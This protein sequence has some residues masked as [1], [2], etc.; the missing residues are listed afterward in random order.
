MQM[1]KQRVRAFF[2]KY[3]MDYQSIDIAEQAE[4]FAREMKRGLAGEGGSL[5]MIP[6]FLGPANKLTANRPV[7]VLDAGGT[8]FRLAVVSFD[9]TNVPRIEDYRACAMPGTNAELESEE[10]FRTIAHLILPVADRSDTI[11]FCFSYACEPTPDCDGIIAEIGKQLQVKGLVGEKLGDRLNEA[12][13][14]L[15]YTRKKRILVINDSVATLLGGVAASGGCR[16]GGYIGFILGTGLNASYAEKLERIPK[17]M[18]GYYSGEELIINTESGDYNGFPCGKLDD[19]YD[20]TLIDPGT[21]R[22]EKMVAGRYQGGLA[23][24]VLRQAAKDGLFSIQFR[25]QI[26]AIKDLTSF[27]LDE[28]LDQPEG[29]NVLAKCCFGADS[30]DAVTAFYIIDALVERAAKLVAVNLAA[31][32]LQMNAGLNPLRPVCVTADGSTFY[33]SRLFRKKLD[34]YV[35][36]SLNGQLGLYCKFNH[37]ADVNLIGTAVAGLCI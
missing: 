6:T 10:F 7:L 36:Q 1:I 15:G 21:W 25:N 30:V 11:A 19:I 29:D 12:L 27:Q 23:L 37:V 3:S 8:N 2:K 34:Y 9:E 32:M 14:K 33:K 20:A 31:L 26:Q 18:S 24:V 13:S 35:K 5:R 16:Y 17:I 28:F 22:Y 4:R